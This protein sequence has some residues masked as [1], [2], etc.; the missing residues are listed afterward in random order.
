MIVI[1]IILLLIYG[2]F[3]DTISIFTGSCTECR[4]YMK[5][6]Y[7]FLRKITFLYALVNVFCYKCI[8]KYYVAHV[9]K[10]LI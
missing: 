1:V 9:R 2:I 7:I 4:E 3:V 5:V 10:Q 6:N 8:G